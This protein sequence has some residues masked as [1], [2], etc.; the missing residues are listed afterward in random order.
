MSIIYLRHKTIKAGEKKKYSTSH[1]C[2][3]E[4]SSRSHIKKDKSNKLG[5]DYKNLFNP[6]N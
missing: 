6:I 1:I 4:F 5:L 2:H 3:L